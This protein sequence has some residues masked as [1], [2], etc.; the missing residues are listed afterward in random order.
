M[1]CCSVTNKCPVVSTTNQF[2]TSNYS[3]K[4]GLS[5]LRTAK[6]IIVIIYLHYSYVYKQNSWSTNTK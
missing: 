6:M 1:K 2:T 5:I 3:D 4:V